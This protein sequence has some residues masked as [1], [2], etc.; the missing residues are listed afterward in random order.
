MLVNSL[1]LENFFK[2]KDKLYLE[3]ANGGADRFD[4]LAGILFAAVLKDQNYCDLITSLVKELE[5]KFSRKGHP[6]SN[7]ITR[8]LSRCKLKITEAAQLKGMYTWTV[9][10]PPGS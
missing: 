9:G 3:V 8:M 2:I 4:A 6:D 1:A 5:D 7:L 10:T